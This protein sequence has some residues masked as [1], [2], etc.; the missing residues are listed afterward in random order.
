[1]RAGRAYSGT[2]RTAVTFAALSDADVAWYVST[3]EPRDKAGAYHVDGRGALFITRI[4][5]SPSNVA[6]LPVRLLRR[7]AR[8]AAVDLG[9][10]SALRAPAHEEAGDAVRDRDGG[11]RAGRGRVAGPRAHRALPHGGRRA[12]GPGGAVRDRARGP[13]RARP[14]GHAGRGHGRARAG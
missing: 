12:G 6:G 7:P 14:P 11:A 9:W 8:G 5:G 3:G 2:E 10:P 13:P 4:D 1:V